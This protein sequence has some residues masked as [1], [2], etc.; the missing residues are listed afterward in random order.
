MADPVAF[1]GS[2]EEKRRCFF[3]IY[4]ELENRIKIFAS[5][6]IEALDSFALQDRVKEIGRVKLPEGRE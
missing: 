2:H 3:R 6:R 4:R 5:L 1:E